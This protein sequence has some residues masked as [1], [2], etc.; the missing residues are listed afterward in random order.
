MY[1]VVL[2]PCSSN[3]LSLLSSTLPFL[4][5]LSW[6]A[7]PTRPTLHFK[8]RGKGRKAR[9]VF[10]THQLHALEDKF[11]AHKYLSV[12]QRLKIAEHLNLT[13][14]QV[15]TWFQNRRTK[16]KKRLREPDELSSEALEDEDNTYNASDTDSE[17][18]P[19]EDHTTDPI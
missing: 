18:Q 1:F 7:L 11:G 3:Q 2:E 4:T 5:P 14:E 6:P 10:T 12:P 17:E 13:E 9:T 19:M 16:W 15:K 8:G